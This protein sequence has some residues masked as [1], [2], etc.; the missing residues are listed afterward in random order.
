MVL[1]LRE[2]VQLTPSKQADLPAEAYYTVFFLCSCLLWTLVYA[3]RF[4]TLQPPHIEL[5]PASREVGCDVTQ[6]VFL[7]C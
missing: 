1:L 4:R 3:L 5:T 2:R 7:P 6:K